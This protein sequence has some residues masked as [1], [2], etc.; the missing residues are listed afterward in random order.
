MLPICDSTNAPGRDYVTYSR[1]ES[2]VGYC[3]ERSGSH[4]SSSGAVPTKAP[5]GHHVQGLFHKLNEHGLQFLEKTN[6]NKLFTQDFNTI[7]F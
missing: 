4:G 5:G 6:F 1:H 3:V 7:Y 2:T